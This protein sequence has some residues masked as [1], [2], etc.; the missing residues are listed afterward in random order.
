MLL[1]DKIAEQIRNA[2]LYGMNSLTDILQRENYGQ[3]VKEDKI[4]FVVL[5]RYIE[6]LERYY[7]DNWDNDG[8][9]M[10]TVWNRKILIT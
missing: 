1:R 3:N 10:R 7:V 9:V 5:H 2:K 8:N 6:A 4:R